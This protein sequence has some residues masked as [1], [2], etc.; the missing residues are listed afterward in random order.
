MNFYPVWPPLITF[1]G[2]FWLAD[3]RLFASADAP[4]A[5]RL[6][7]LQTIDGLRG[8]LALSVVLF[9]GAVYHRYLR[10]G[11]WGGPASSGY[12]LLGTGGVAVFFMITG[13]LFWCRIIDE[14]GRPDWARFYIGRVFRIAP[15]YLISIVAMVILV[16][17]QAGWQL[18]VPAAM[19]VQELAPWLALGLLNPTDLNGH[20]ATL[21]LTAGVAWSLR[22]EWLF[23]LALPAFAL[24]AGRSSVRL[25]V[26]LVATAAGFCW[27]LHGGPHF[28]APGDPFYSTLFL[29]GIACAA[30]D[31]G[32]WAARIDDRLASVAVVALVAI[33]FLTCGIAYSPLA[34]ALLGTCFYLVI[35]GCTVFGVLTRRASKRL[36]DISYGIYLLQG[37]VLAALFQYQPV[38]TFALTSPLRHWAVVLSGAMILVGLAALTHAWIERPGIALGRRIARLLPTSAMLHARAAPK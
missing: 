38:R 35:S 37:L 26:A 28:F 14:R 19:F 24:A 31:R 33:L 9:H 27:S 36:G 12:T 34:M 6:A 4:P 22:Y 11:I 18:R 17:I 15:L 29:I 5:P 25:G 13:Y 7:R 20:P 21:I 23:Y 16:M 30:A 1:I 10:D 3:T 32:G 2:L 8:F